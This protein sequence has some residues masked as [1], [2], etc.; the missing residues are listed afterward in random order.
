[1]AF[2]FKF[3]F[4]LL[5]GIG[6]IIGKLTRFGNPAPAGIIPFMLGII[7]EGMFG[8]LGTFRMPFIIIGMEFDVGG[9]IIGNPRLGEPKGI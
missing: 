6:G 7:P 8:M 9:Y 3:I 5:G 4:I 1:M 2:I